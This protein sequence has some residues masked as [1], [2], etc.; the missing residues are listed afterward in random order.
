MKGTNSMKTIYFLVLAVLLISFPSCEKV[1][2][3]GLG[4]VEGIVRDY[5]GLDGC[6]FIIELVNGDKL[7]PV[8]VTDTNFVFMD[9]Q[10]VAVTYTE[11]TDVG[12]YCM[13]GIMVR[14]ETIRLTSCTPFNHADPGKLPKDPVI[15]D[16]LAINGNCLYLTVHYG[17]GCETHEFQLTEL[18]TLMASTYGMLPVLL[19]SH[20]A[21]NDMCE[22]WI[23][24][25]FS[26]NLIELRNPGADSTLF[27]L[28]LNIEGSDY[29]E[30]INYK[31]P[32]A[33]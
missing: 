10:R 30:M 11:L 20:E 1:I 15:L 3:T 23:Q 12:S 4:E 7:E 28:K 32:E 27:I 26:F 17:G 29:L 18:Q 25:Y 16:S 22:A 14:I 21:N 33:H 24:D 31:Y 8:E 6:G 5:T 19:L 2:P 13:V 9:G